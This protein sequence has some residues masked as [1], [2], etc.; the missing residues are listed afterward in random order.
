MATTMTFVAA[1]AEGHELGLEAKRVTRVVTRCDWEGPEPPDL[2]RLVAG[3]RSDAN[4]RHVLVVQVDS[5]E[6][7]VGTAREL[8]LRDLP[9]TELHTVPALVWDAEQAPV[10]H[11]IGALPDALPLLVLDPGK[12]RARAVASHAHGGSP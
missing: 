12:L 6:W 2:E 5:E 9:E 1:R 11:R 10:I 7:S 8:V 4:C 3:V